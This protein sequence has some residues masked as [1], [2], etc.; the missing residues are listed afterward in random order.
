MEEDF[1]I[2][3]SKNRNISRRK[4]AI[5]SLKTGEK[6]FS[7]RYTQTGLEKILYHP[8]YNHHV[9][10]NLYQESLEKGITKV[11]KKCSTDV[12][13][14][15]MYFLINGLSVEKIHNQRTKIIS[16]TSKK[17]L[18][19]PYYQELINGEE[20][21]KVAE[22]YHFDAKMRKNVARNLKARNIKINRLTVSEKSKK[23]AEHS[24]NNFVNDYGMEISK[25]IMQGN[26]I[27][28]IRAELKEKYNL[29]K[30]PVKKVVDTFYQEEYQHLQYLFKRE[31]KR[32][33]QK[34]KYE[35]R[36]FKKEKNVQGYIYRITNELNGKTYIGQHKKDFFDENYYGSGVLIKEAV[37][38]YGKYNF[39]QVILKICF[40]Q[41]ELDSEEQKFIKLEREQGHAEYN[42]TD[43]GKGMK[44]I[45]FKGSQNP[46]YGHHHTEETR[47]KL[48]KYASQRTGES[49][50]FYGHKMTPEHLAKT[51]RTGSTQNAETKRKISEARKKETVCPICKQ[52]FPSRKEMTEH[53]KK[54]HTPDN[55]KRN[56]QRMA[57]MQKMIF[58][59]PYCQKEIHSKG[60]LTQHVRA[61]H[62]EKLSEYNYKKR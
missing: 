32:L 2:N 11:A 43:G 49:N 9:V 18:D 4:M 28:E 53:Y 30:C 44:G 23:Q 26:S 21:N 1:L 61:S 47:N 40:S 13:A 3:E 33:K 58:V 14:L 15:K 55:K 46:F 8:K 60:N 29:I 39:N 10:E 54:V 17:T 48:S 22:K 34:K 62:K 24:F 19:K 27:D 35:E 51:R 31:E 5:D 16:N 59:C 42:I 52:I 56:A 7:F 41:D 6:I 38:K 36:K 12:R 57:E 20:F 50:P 45:H 25:K 37:R